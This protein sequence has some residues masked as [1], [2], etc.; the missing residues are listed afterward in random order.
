M[1]PRNNFF[2]FWTSKKWG[3]SQ[4]DDV[5]WHQLICQCFRVKS[6]L[7]LAF[8]CLLCGPKMFFDSELNNLTDSKESTDIGHARF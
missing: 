2:Q 3:P 7:Q 5:T 4:A 8:P 6:F 1:S